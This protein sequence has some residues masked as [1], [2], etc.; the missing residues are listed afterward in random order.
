M[1]IEKLKNCCRADVENKPKGTAKMEIIFSIK[2]AQMGLLIH[3]MQRWANATARI[4][5][6]LR[7]CDL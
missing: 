6:N 2:K 7:T 5:D 4:K 1:E 3:Q